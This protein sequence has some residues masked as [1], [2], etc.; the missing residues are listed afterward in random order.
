MLVPPY[1]CLQELTIYSY[2]SIESQKE[3]APQTAELPLAILTLRFIPYILRRNIVFAN[4]EFFEEI[5]LLY[6]ASGHV[7]SALANAAFHS[8]PAPSALFDADQKV[9]HVNGAWKAWFGDHVAKEGEAWWSALE[10]TPDN[11]RVL[12]RWQEQSSTD[13]ADV[14]CLRC[15]PSSREIRHLL[16]ITK[17]E[18]EGE[19]WGC[20]TFTEV[21]RGEEDR[22]PCSPPPSILPAFANEMAS[23]VSTALGWIRL[24]RADEQSLDPALNRTLEAVEKCALSQS[25][26]VGDVR[27][28]LL[29][30]QGRRKISTANVVISELAHTVV[31]SVQEEAA[32]GGILLRFE[33]PKNASHQAELHAAT[34]CRSLREVLQNAI[35]HTNRGGQVLVRV[36]AH[37]DYVYVEVEDDGVGLSPQRLAVL[38]GPNPQGNRLSRDSVGLHLA[39]AVGFTEHQGGH[40]EVYSRGEK[41]G[42]TFRLCFPASSKS[43]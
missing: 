35:R 5:S 19:P 38:L 41:Q 21:L 23:S 7:P 16:R 20:V 26:L 8:F 34:F 12:S 31:E 39:L 24:Y 6:S 10:E 28:L 4:F 17:I 15:A 14:I 18:A 43:S 33:P 37:G 9:R 29:L 2:K 42:S 36:E 3:F 1:S 30:D 25:S 40:V 22:S 13:F 32:A 11:T 27:R